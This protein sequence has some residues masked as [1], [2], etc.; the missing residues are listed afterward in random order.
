M[1][2]LESSRVVSALLSVCEMSASWSE[3][4]EIRDRCGADTVSS[5]SPAVLATAA[6]SVLALAALSD[7]T[8]RLLFAGGVGEPY[9][10]CSAQLFELVVT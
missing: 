5:A 2:T 4:A 6:G 9:G 10:P 8:F 3:L 7:D 1:A